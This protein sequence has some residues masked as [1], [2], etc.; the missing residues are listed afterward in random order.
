MQSYLFMDK[1]LSWY[2][3][4]IFPTADYLGVS[5]KHFWL[6]NPSDAIVLRK[7]II[8]NPILSNIHFLKNF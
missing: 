4:D 5:Y 7:G 3:S 2:S 8:Y 1:D 6:I